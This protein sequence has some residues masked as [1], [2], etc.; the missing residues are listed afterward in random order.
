MVLISPDPL[1]QTSSMKWSSS[2]LILGPNELDEMVLVHAVRNRHLAEVGWVGAHSYG[3]NSNFNACNILRHTV[4][5][6]LSLSLL[7]N[8]VYNL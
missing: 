4:L 8:C 2:H 3:E 5:L 6:D 1:A 7:Q